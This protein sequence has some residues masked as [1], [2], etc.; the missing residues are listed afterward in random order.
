MDRRRR[1][2]VGAVVVILAALAGAGLAG[3]GPGPSGPD[4]SGPDG[5]ATEATPLETPAPATERDRTA[6]PTAATPRESPATGAAT[7]DGERATTAERSRA[8]PTAARP[9]GD[10]SGAPEA[11]DRRQTADSEPAAASERATRSD[12][13]TPTPTP[14]P[15]VETPVTEPFAVDIDRI[16]SCGRFCRDVTASLTNRQDAAATNVV[17]TTRLYPG[18]RTDGRPVWTGEVAVG[19][20]GPGATATTNE[21]VELSVFDAFAVS[22]AGG[23]V[24]VSTTIRSDR[25]TVTVTER[26]QV[27]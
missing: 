12:G 21:R 19:T 16:E 20:L 27:A 23:W 14:A 4:D 7:T 9:A 6:P 17:V 5:T 1:L 15:V 3:L 24:T 13:R 26:R 18:N 2:A 8:T 10:G 25:R 11:P 22:D